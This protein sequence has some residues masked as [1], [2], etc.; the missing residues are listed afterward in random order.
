MPFLRLLFL[1]IL[2]SEIKA[3]TV[4]SQSQTSKSGC[5]DKCGNVSVPYPFGIGDDCSIDEQFNLTCDASFSPPKLFLPNGNIDVLEISLLYGYLRIHVWMARDCYN[6]SGQEDYSTTTELAQFTFSD[7]RN[8]F[9]AIGCDTIAFINGTEGQSYASGCISLCDDIANVINGSC[10]GI[11]CCQTTI[12][13]GVMKYDIKI[14]SRNNHANILSFNP[15]SYAFLVEQNQFNFSSSYLQDFNATEF[16]VILDWAVGNETCEEAK[17]RTTAA[18]ECHEN[19]YCYNS[20]NGRPGYLCNCTQGYR[21]NPYLPP[22]C[23]DIDECSDPKFNNCLL[24]C[25]NTAGSFYCSCPAGYHG[26]GIRGGQGCEPDPDDVNQRILGIKIAVGTCLGVLS[27][28]VCSCLLYWTIR[29]RRLILLREKFFQQNGG[30]LLQQQIASRRGVSEI[31]MIFTEED[32]KKATKNFDESRVIG[33]GGYGTVYKGILPNNRIVAIK[34]SKI[35]DKSQISQF[36]N[37]VEI[38][39]QINHRNVVKLLGCCLETEV[40]LLVYEFISNGTLSQHIHHESNESSIPWEDRLRIAA[41]TA[42]ALAYL[43]SAHSIPVLHRDMKSANILLDENYVAKISDFGASRLV[44]LDQTQMTTLV[45]GTLGYLDPECFH[46]GQ[47]TEKSDVYSFGV[48]L[49]EI[50]TGEKPLSLER[51]GE[52][53]SLAMYFVSSMKENR[54]FQI[55]EDGIVDEK[56]KEQLMAVSELAR[57]CL[58]VKGE[59]RP[60]MK[61]VAAELEG[62]RRFQE[63]PWVQQNHEETEYL[64]GKPSSYSVGDVNCQE[65]LSDGFIMALEIAR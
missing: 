37:E 36:I 52:Y 63:H 21:G 22:G 64:L 32:L 4:A 56:N 59:D 10:A 29:R 16:P 15:C 45:Q 9:T 17:S 58:K 49:A 27:L 38:L 20:I 35:M 12:P 43:H 18:A 51:P 26:D 42:G 1:L 46:T 14:E 55:L 53:K 33:Q 48:V 54:L 65:S 62:L 13:K 39:S 5:P 31:A 50:L 30:L 3:A 24:Q 19:S 34:K 40:P 41:E 47:L 11:G 60:T 23:Q 44:P 2:L 61:E 28:L 57:R 7:T 25:N 8:R 6:K